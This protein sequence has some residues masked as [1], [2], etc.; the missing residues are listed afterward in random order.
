MS[1]KSNISVAWILRLVLVCCAM[2]Y[3]IRSS[4]S[5][6]QKKNWTRPCVWSGNTVM[7]SCPMMATSPTMMVVWV[8]DFRCA[9]VVMREM[10]PR[11]RMIPRVTHCARRAD[12][13]KAP[14]MRWG[15]IRSADAP[16]TAPMIL[17]M[18]MDFFR[19]NMGK[20]MAIIRS[21][22]RK[23]PIFAS[24]KD[25]EGWRREKKDMGELYVL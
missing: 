17:V 16:M 22:R 15:A 6:I 4:M 24:I 8:S 21:Q 23:M 9:G 5:A 13:V 2:A 14:S 20:I 19:L 10:V 25:M 1:P 3:L 18:M 7:R 12:D 11:V